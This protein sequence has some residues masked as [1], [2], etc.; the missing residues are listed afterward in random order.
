MS[1]TDTLLG[2]VPDPASPLSLAREA[3]GHTV[4]TVSGRSVQ[5]A[6]RGGGGSCEAALATDSRL[7][8]ANKEQW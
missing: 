6:G 7:N 3:A 5:Q 4:Y 8:T 2:R 1:T